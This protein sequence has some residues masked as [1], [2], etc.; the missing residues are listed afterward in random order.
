MSANPTASNTAF[1]FGG[2][3]AA[4]G[5][6]AGLA[7]LQRDGEVWPG[8]DTPLDGIGGQFQPGS[9]VFA[10]PQ[11]FIRRYGRAFVVVKF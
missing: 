5:T 6:F 3:P 7:R 4:G 2:E 9:H 11:F 1:D 10:R 8:D